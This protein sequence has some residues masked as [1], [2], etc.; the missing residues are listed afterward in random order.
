VIG[1]VPP[2]AIVAGSPAKVIKY[3]FNSKVIETLLATKWWM[4]DIDEIK[5]KI[6]VLE[7]IVEEVK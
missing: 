4:W 2:Y 3:R 6:S 5:K 7:S 1:Y